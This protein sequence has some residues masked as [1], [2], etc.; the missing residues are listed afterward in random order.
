MTSLNTSATGLDT[1]QTGMDVIANNIANVNTVGF[2]GSQVHFA[3]AYYDALKLASK[4]IPVNTQVGNG[5]AVEG[6]ATHFTQ[7]ALQITNTPSDVGIQ[8]NGF[9][10]TS[11]A[12]G[13]T[14]TSYTRSGQ[15]IMD[16]S[17][18]IRGQDGSYVNGTGNFGLV[19]AN[20]K[21]PIPTGV[22]ANLTAVRIPQSLANGELV[23][24]YSIGAD[25]AISVTGNLGSAAVI[26]YLALATFPDNTGLQQTAGTNF[27]ATAASGTPSYY[28]P[29]QGTAGSVQG[30]A[31]ESSNVN[32]S[33]EFSNMIITQQAFN[34]CAKGLTVSDQILQT[35]IGLKR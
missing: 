27:A 22:L 19:A 14:P 34:A 9:F 30:G 11:G 5:V 31:V 25:G 17:R 20:A 2:R 1:M 16:N 4:T 7:G 3:D 8:G 6:T 23:T 18:Y 35:T 28:A 21:L 32:L 33:A 12:V 15:F 10:A 13:A 24:G 29:T 26:G